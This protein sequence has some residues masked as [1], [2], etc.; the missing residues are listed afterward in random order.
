MARIII[1]LFRIW[2]KPSKASSRT[3]RGLELNGGPTRRKY[4]GI[5]KRLRVTKPK[6]PSQPTACNAGTLCLVTNFSSHTIWLAV[7]ICAITISRSPVIMLLIELLLLPDP[8]MKSDAPTTLRP[9]MTV[10]IPSHSRAFKSL[11]RKAVDKS[12][13][14]IM[15]APITQQEL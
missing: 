7:T 15:T 2:I 12:P 8:K 5:S 13:V 9:M 1:G 10:N 4:M 3:I 14:K 11:P 6:I